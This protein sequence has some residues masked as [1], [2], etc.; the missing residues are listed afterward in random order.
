MNETK[1]YPILI[2][3]DNKSIFEDFCKIL[4]PPIECDELSS[5][6]SELFSSEL[7]QTSGLSLQPV[8][9]Q[10]VID[11]A[12]QGEEGYYKILAAQSAGQPYMIAFCDMRMP[13]GWDGL[14][15]MEHI[16]KKDSNIQLVICTAFSDHSFEEINVR[17]G[18][19]SNVLALKK[20]F[21]PLEVRQLANSLTEKWV[22]HEVANLQMSRLEEMVKAR[23]EAVQ[24]S[25]ERI[26]VINRGLEIEVNNRTQDLL[27]AKLKAEAAN[28]AKGHFLSTV[29]HELRTPLHGILSFSSF[30]ISKSESAS[31]EK[32]LSY[33]TKI[34]KCGANLLTLVNSLLD[35]AKLEA[36][37]MVF[38]FEKSKMEGLV[39]EVVDEFRSICIDKSVSLNISA[40]G[41]VVEIILDSSK[42]K[43]VIRNLISNAMKFSP[44]NSGINID[45]IYTT[46]GINVKVADQGQG[47][48]E[49]ELSIIFD[50]FSQSKNIKEAT[51]GTG[52][53]LAIC[54]EI[55]AGHHGQ[56][57]A[58]N[59]DDGGACFIFTLHINQLIQK[60]S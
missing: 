28:E 18:N 60:V 56:I 47:I 27:A 41:P 5:I 1:Q 33:F 21:D 43:Q 16:V 34:N 4:L 44:M 49:D 17:L 23:T 13:P 54:Q 32:K 58:E 36:G 20:P 11:Y 15:T 45:I 10:Y 46:D 48:A 37:K 3:D 35:L 50:K 42:I 24:E 30:G 59:N 22:S 55:I 19:N 38:T 40:S 9:K 25:E 29:S 6:E 51:G 14:K 57:W 8:N 2:I 52:L 26:K 31:D 39:E 53:G 12:S 7:P